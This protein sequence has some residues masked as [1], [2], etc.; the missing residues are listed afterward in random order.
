[1]ALILL[2]IEEIDSVENVVSYTPF[3]SALRSYIFFFF[4]SVIIS[5]VNFAT[6]RYLRGARI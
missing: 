3:V 4:L 2:A 5:D 6:V 1:M